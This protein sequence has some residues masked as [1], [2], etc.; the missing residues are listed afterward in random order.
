MAQL[1]AWLAHQNGMHEDEASL[2]R[3]QDRVCYLAES[4]LTLRLYLLTLI[5]WSRTQGSAGL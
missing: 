2:P 3:I 1:G 5:W 4:L